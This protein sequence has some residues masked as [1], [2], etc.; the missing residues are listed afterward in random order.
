[1]DKKAKNTPEIIEQ[2]TPENPETTKTPDNQSRI[3][4]IKERHQRYKINQFYAKQQVDAIQ[5]ATLE[6]LG[7][8]EMPQ[9]VKIGDTFISIDQ[10]KG[11]GIHMTVVEINSN[12]I[13]VT[14]MIDNNK[15]A[16][17]LIN[18]GVLETYPRVNKAGNN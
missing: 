15:N 12:R 1:M 18:M 6:R 11:R 4:L 9:E 13:N 3:D 16:T 2:D 10:D 7:V 14:V 5:K 8:I 17:M